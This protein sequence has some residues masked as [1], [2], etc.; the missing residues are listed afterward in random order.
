M[1]FQAGPLYDSTIPLRTAYAVRS[2]F[3]FA[4]ILSRMLIDCSIFWSFYLGLE[5]VRS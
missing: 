5:W 2:A 1:K 4:H 3:V